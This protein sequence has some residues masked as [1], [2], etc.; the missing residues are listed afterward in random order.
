MNFRRSDI[1]RSAKLYFIPDPDLRLLNN[2]KYRECIDAIHAGYIRVD[3]DS[4]QRL[5][6]TAYLDSRT[7]LDF[8][9]AVRMAARE[10]GFTVNSAWGVLHR[11]EQ[12]VEGELEYRG[13]RVGG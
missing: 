6:E 3:S 5:I 10:C 8:R 4:K 13:H 12:A 11:F 1:T 9:D 7:S 2:P